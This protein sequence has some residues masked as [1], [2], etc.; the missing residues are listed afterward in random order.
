M[1][2]FIVTKYLWPILIFAFILRAGVR[3]HLGETEFWINGYTFFF[4]IAENIA[5]GKGMGLDSDF[6]TAIRVPVYPI[7]LA[8]VTLGHREFISIILFQSLIGAGTVLCSALI[9]REMFG[10]FAALIAAFIT[11]LYPYFV[12]HDTALQETSLFT[13]FTAL[14]VLLLMQVRR[15][16]SGSKAAYAGIALGMAVLTRANIAPF[17][18]LAPLWLIVPPR[19]NGLLWQRRFLTCLLCASA[20]AITVSPWLARSYWLTGSLTLSTESGRFLWL[21]NN[22]YT[23]SHYPIEDIDRSGDVAL[24]ALSPQDVVEIQELRPSEAA[25]DEWF[26]KKGL[27]YIRRHPW[28]TIANGF[29]KISA[30][31]CLLPSPRHSFWQNLFYLLSYGPVITLGLW[32]M[33][34]GRRNWRERLPFYILFVTF[35]LVTAV[36]FGHTSYRAYLDVYLIVF[37]AGVIQ[38]RIEA[39]SDHLYWRQGHSRNFASHIWHAIRMIFR[40]IFLSGQAYLQ[41][42]VICLR[43]IGYLGAGTRTGIVR[44][45][46]DRWPK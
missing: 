37:A 15:N 46:V 20:I 45:Q 2:N 31:F 33:W 28:R 36:F 12:V 14:A 8:T 21:G 18:M 23:F 40:D 17:A 26:F 13:F 43:N 34:V 3:L 9:A 29:W 1:S 19:S 7:F 6:A 24:D 22:E 10:D 32:G 30:A 35:A 27:D 39:F 42:T 5:G 41:R 11:A 44:T 38:L 4:D 25:V 16:G